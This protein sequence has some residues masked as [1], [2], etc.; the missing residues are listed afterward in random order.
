MSVKLMKEFSNYGFNITVWFKEERGEY[1]V[2]EYT[3][4]GKEDKLDPQ[5]VREYFWTRKHSRMPLDVV[6]GYIA[7][8]VRFGLLQS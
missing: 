1:Y 8:F 4:G 2:W 3:V 7:D 6:C 5:K